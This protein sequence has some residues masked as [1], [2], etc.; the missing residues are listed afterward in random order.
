MGDD[1][2]EILIYFKSS[3]D[4]VTFSRLINVSFPL[5]RT[6]GREDFDE[7]GIFELKV[8][9]AKPKNSAEPEIFGMVMHYAAQMS[10]RF[11]PP[12]HIK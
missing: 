12:R 5:I 9:D 6:V 4:R 10:K 7:F 1:E 2:S 11:K 8:V 3:K